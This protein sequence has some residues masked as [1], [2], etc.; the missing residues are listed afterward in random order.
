MRIA[1]VVGN[2]GYSAVAKLP[3]PQR[4]AEAIAEALKRDGF[5]DVMLGSDL[6]RADLV[7]ALNDFADKAAKADWAVVYFAGHGIELDGVNY[8]IPVDARLKSDR[9]VQDEAVSLDRVVASVEGARKL[10]LVILDAC[11]NNPFVTDMR[12]TVASRAI[13]RGLARVEPSGATLVAYAAKGG[14]EAVDG[15]G[16]ANSPFAA[17]LVKRLATPGL[18]VGKLFRLVRDDVLAA[19]ERKQE[20]FVYGSLPGED[21]FFR[22]E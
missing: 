18:E 22:P 12:L 15:D 19:T 1:L 13:H 7:Q 17:A 11:R 5:Q 6:N 16:T 21:F 8:L 2:S 14:E 20:P 9:D 3:N 10:K 4:D